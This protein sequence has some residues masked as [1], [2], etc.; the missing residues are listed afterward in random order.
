MIKIGFTRRYAKQKEPMTFLEIA[1]QVISKRDETE[2]IYIGDGEFQEQMQEWIINNNLTDKIHMLGFRNDSAE[3]VGVFDVYLSTALYEGLPYSM[4]E[5]MRAGVPIIA[6]DC[7]GNNELVF[8][9]IN[10]HMFPVGDIGRGVKCLT[11]Q[12][13]NEVIKKENVRDT[14]CKTFSLNCM[15][16]GIMRLYAG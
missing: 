6:T 4:I 2:F 8:E 3:I 9:G 12:I 10:G 7:I 1:K 13:E 11:F 5:A 14:F 15:L 16:D